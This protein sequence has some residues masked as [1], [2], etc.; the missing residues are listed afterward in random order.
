MTTSDPQDAFSV[1]CHE[2]SVHIV[3]PIHGDW[4]QRREQMV[5]ELEQ[6][7]QQAL[8]YA[9]SPQFRKRYQDRVGVVRVQTESEAPTVVEGVLAER[10]IE[11]ENVK[12]QRP[13]DGPSC[14]L[15]PR[16]RLHPK[17]AAMSECGWVCPS[18]LRALSLRHQ[19]Q[20]RRTPIELR[21]PTRLVLPLVA[22]MASLFVIGVGYELRHLSQ[23]NQVIRAH[24]PKE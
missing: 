10:G 16:Q 12:Q 24:L 3:I 15:C 9:E 11:L 4:N 18:C 5:F 1:L 22:V 17:Q 2:H 20:Q 14:A 6:R 7:T 19:P 13:L 21:I 23:M 8:C